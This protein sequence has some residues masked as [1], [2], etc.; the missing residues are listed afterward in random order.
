M[1][2]DYIADGHEAGLVTVRGRG[3][4]LNIYQ[5]FGDLEPTT[6]GAFDG[7]GYTGD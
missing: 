3:A 7:L 5:N 1:L 2:A 4:M 6:E